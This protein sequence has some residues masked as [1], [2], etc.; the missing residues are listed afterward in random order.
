MT[1]NEVH[2]VGKRPG[3]DEKRTELLRDEAFIEAIR[4]VCESSGC[5]YQRFVAAMGPYG[6]WLAEIQRDGIDQRVL[7]NGKDECLV[8]QVKLP[9]G[10][11]EDPVSLEVPEQTAD[12][13]VERVGALLKVKF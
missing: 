9:E 11:W 2:W 8:L 7:W 1:D 4:A 5:R 10:G 6:T 13:F 3:Q 12:G